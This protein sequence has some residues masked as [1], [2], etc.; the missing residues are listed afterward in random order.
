[1]PTDER[2]ARGLV[3][4]PHGIGE[5]RPRRGRM[6]RVAILQHRTVRIACVGSRYARKSVANRQ[7]A[8]KW[9]QL[10]AIHESRYRKQGFR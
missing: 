4:E 10:F 1:M 2:E 7:N 3:R 5:L 6:A 8:K 9:Q